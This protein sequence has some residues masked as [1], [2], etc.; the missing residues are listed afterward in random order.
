MGFTGVVNIIQIIQILLRFE[1]GKQGQGLGLP[2][3]ENI[4][5]HLTANMEACGVHVGESLVSYAG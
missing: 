4:I 3:Q 5:M 2:I 1:K